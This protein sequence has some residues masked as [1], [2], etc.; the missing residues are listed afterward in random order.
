MMSYKQ[1]INYIDQLKHVKLGFV[2]AVLRK[3][4]R[5]KI[6]GNPG[7]NVF[8]V[9]PGENVSE[10]IQRAVDYADRQALIEGQDYDRGSPPGSM[11]ILEIR[12][13]KEGWSRER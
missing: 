10:A 9:V 13:A 12:V 2:P 1:I 5:Y 3:D 7:E 8:E 6:I 11:V 4:G